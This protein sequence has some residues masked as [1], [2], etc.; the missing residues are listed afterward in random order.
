MSTTIVE[1]DSSS[2]AAAILIFVLFAVLIV[3]GV[4]FA[5]ANGVLGKPTVIE[6]TK[7]VVPTP[8]VPEPAPA[9]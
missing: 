4:W 9:K 7:V 1:R 8:S 2:P 3:G 5:Y 6:H